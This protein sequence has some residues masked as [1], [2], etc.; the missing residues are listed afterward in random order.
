MLAYAA[1][2]EKYPHNPWEGCW[3]IGGL[4]WSP[5][6]NQNGY[7]TPPYFPAGQGALFA[8][9]Y[10]EDARFFY[11]P[12]AKGKNDSVPGGGGYLTYDNVFLPHQKNPSENPNWDQNL[13]D[14][15]NIAWD[16]VFVGYP[17]WAGWKLKKPYEHLPPGSDYYGRLWDEKLEKVIAK[18]P[19]SRSST[20]IVTDAA[21]T[22]GAQSD[23]EHAEEY[24]HGFSNHV[25]NGAV[26]GSNNLHNDG[27]VEWIKFK[28]MKDDGRTHLRLI[29]GTLDFWF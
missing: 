23:I 7:T 5:Q 9:G 12:A 2:N 28:T 14:P 3:P 24:T 21:I 18:N 29:H 16:V 15:D 6:Y 1:D 10:I 11:C 20:I 8:G 25:R 19:M 22:L 17:Y 27:S 13:N 26:T 4:V